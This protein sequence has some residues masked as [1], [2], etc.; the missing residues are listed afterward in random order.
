MAQTDRQTNR[1]GES[2]QWGQYSEKHYTD[3]AKWV[4]FLLVE[5]H[6]KGS[7]LNIFHKD[8]KMAGVAGP[9]FVSIFKHFMNKKSKTIPWDPIVIV[10]QYAFL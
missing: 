1:H 7:A 4:D 8:Y 9:T 10:I 3:F 2:A 5:L 6:Q